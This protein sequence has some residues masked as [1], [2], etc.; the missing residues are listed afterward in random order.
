MMLVQNAPKVGRAMRRPQH[1][2][3]LRSYPWEIQPFLLAPVLPGE[4]MKNAMFQSRVVTNPL[5]NRLIGWWKEYYLFYVK[6]RDLDERD[7]LTQMMLDLNHSTSSLPAGAGNNDYPHYVYDGGIDW[8]S[9]CLKRVVEEFFRDEGEAWNVALGPSGLPLALACDQRWLDSVVEGSHT[10]ATQDITLT[11]TAGPGVA[12]GDN[13]AAVTTSEIDRAMRT[14]EILRMQGL[15]TISYEDFLRSHGVS[16]PEAEEPHRPELLRYVR[17]WTYPTNTVE[18]TTGLASSCCSW[19]ISERADK[20]R[21]FKEPGFIFGVTV[22]RPKIYFGN[23]A[24]AAA[25]MLR[26]M[27]PWLPS[28]MWDD[29]NS[30]IVAHAEGDGPL[31]SLT[32]SSGP[33]GYLTD[34]RDLFL[35]G[36]Q[37][38]NFDL[39]A[40]DANLLPLPRIESNN[41][42]KRYVAST[43]IA[44]L[45]GSYI[46][47]G[48][49]TPVDFDP[50]VHEDGACTFSILSHQRDFTPSTGSAPFA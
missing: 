2:F 15:T 21:F 27:L 4:T 40:T 5:R 43:D 30:S 47:A 38:L 36:D 6:H 41:L 7:D 26:G 45:F 22:T 23:Q 25:G 39:T 10:D 13:N 46:P 37:F 11:S 8:S 3:Q 42:V 33:E 28:V 24:G 17:D 35:Y 19:S 29:P 49:E 34:A 18:P 14:W 9:M 1:T 31:Q 20:D 48:E 12:H 16:V 50:L 44:D 32:W